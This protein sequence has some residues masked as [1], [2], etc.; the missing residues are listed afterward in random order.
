MCH[1]KQ[2]KDIFVWNTCWQ[3]YS[4]CSLLKWPLLRFNFLTDLCG[5]HYPDNE[6]D[7]QFTIVY[8]MHNWYENKR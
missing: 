4:D 6:V 2:E 5:I 3:N 8:H 7:R 1:F